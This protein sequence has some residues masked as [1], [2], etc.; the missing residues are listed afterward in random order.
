M[1]VAPIALA[2]I[3]LLGAACFG[4]GNAAGAAASGGSAVLNWIVA[5]AVLLTIIGSLGIRWISRHASIAKDA[6][7]E[8]Y[9]GP[10]SVDHLQ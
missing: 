4:L 7:I 5:L 9:Q 10:V 3:G 1:G 8:I 2:G 6:P